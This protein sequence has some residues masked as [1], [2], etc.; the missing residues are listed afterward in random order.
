[1]MVQMFRPLG[2]KNTD[3]AVPLEEGEQHRGRNRS[4]RHRHPYPPGKGRTNP[5]GKFGYSRYIHSRR[6][7][8]AK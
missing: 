1:M 6:F 4:R 3:F 8:K 7:Q 2:E 5:P